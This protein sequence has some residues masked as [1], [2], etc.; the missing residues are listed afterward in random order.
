MLE[1]QPTASKCKAFHPL[2]DIFPLMEGDE[3]D[4][5]VGDMKHRGFRPQFPIVT[6]E[7]QIIDGRNRARACEKAGVEPHYTE[8]Q[9]KA[10]D[11]ERFIIQANIHRRHLTADQKRH[12]LKKLLK[13]YPE[14]SD[15]K[16]A[17]EAK[18]SH[19]TV[20]KAR[21]ELEATGQI[22]QLEKTV[23]R[24]HKARK[25]SAHKQPTTARRRTLIVTPKATSSIEGLKVSKA[26][27]PTPII[28]QADAEERQAEDRA[29]AILIDHLDPN[30]LKEF[31]AC[32]HKCSVCVDK[33]ERA[34]N[35]KALRGE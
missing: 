15:R 28:Q 6:F 27:T 13:L 25:R 30:V 33:L 9:A 4:E 35:A 20:S 12:F 21:G 5:L 19:H 1:V 23:G 14:Q 31:I 3:F 2:A 26:E 17:G 18:V 29:I 22:A 7:D 34:A 8:F 11:V 32:L 24:D 10:E 16:I